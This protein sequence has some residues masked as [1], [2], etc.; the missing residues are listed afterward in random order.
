MFIPLLL[1][2]YI[3]ME[4]IERERESSERQ[5]PEMIERERP[6]MRERDFYTTAPCKPLYLHVYRC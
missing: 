5:R 2:N 1:A 6:E 3:Y 4:M